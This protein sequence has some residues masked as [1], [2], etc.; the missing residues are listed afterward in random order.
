MISLMEVEKTGK[1][2]QKAERIVNLN[3]EDVQEGK[4]Y[5]FSFNP[6]DK[7]QY[8]HVKGQFRLRTKSFLDD[9]QRLFFFAGASTR[10]WVEV[11][12]KGRLHYHGVILIHD[13]SL[14]YVYDLTGLE[15]SGALCIKEIDN[16]DKWYEYCQKQFQFHAWLYKE[17][18]KV[19]PIETGEFSKRL[20]R[21]QKEMHPY[22]HCYYIEG[23]ICFWDPPDCL[24]ES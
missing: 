10:T 8:D 23:L 9:A 1:W 11:S 15:K 13:K 17:H 21:W 22:N 2:Q 12:K 7:W 6:M 14:F 3:Y 4:L 16:E 20:G 5:A 19:M 24:P 18:D